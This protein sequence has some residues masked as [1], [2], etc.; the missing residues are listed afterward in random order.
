MNFSQLTVNLSLRL[1]NYRDKC[2]RREKCQS[3]GLRCASSRSS[4]KISSLQETILI[5]NFRQQKRWDEYHAFE[6]TWRNRSTMNRLAFSPTRTSAITETWKTMQRNTQTYTTKHNYFLLN[7]MLCNV[8]WCWF[9]GDG[10][11]LCVLRTF[12]QQF[13][14]CG[15]GDWPLWITVSFRT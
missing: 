10:C 11:S 2:T 6:S 3:N 15:E 8:F 14:D 9:S 5:L 13:Y 4:G 1:G 7:A 12:A